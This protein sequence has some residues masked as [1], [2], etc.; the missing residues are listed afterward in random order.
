MRSASWAQSVP[1]TSAPASAAKRCLVSAFL[2]LASTSIWQGYAPRPGVSPTRRTLR[3]CGIHLGR[4]SVRVSGPAADPVDAQGLQLALELEFA[5]V[6]R[7]EAPVEQA[8]GRL[9]HQDA[10]GLSEVV[11]REGLPAEAFQ[12]RAGVHGIAM[13]VVLHAVRRAE[14]ARGHRPGEDADPHADER[15]A[16]PLERPVE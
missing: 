13:H 9:A 15:Q 4:R 8:Q 5:Q 11:R 10:A 16:A 3:V 6:L 1:D 12:A 2:M 7:L 14:A